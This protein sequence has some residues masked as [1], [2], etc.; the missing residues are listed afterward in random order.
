[1]LKVELNEN[2]A[3]QIAK[4]IYD[5]HKK[6]HLISTSNPKEEQDYS[7]QFKGKIE[8][9]VESLVNKYS[10]DDNNKG[11]LEF[12]SIL[13]IRIARAHA[14]HNGNKRTAIISIHKILESFGYFIK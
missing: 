7:I 1:M 14:W 4:L 10:Y 12:I 8:I 3:N 9:V 6:V 2:L 13:L 5:S 11:I